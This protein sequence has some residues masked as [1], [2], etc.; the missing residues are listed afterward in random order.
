MVGFRG[1]DA[2]E[3]R[4]TIR[5]IAAGTVGS[6]VLYDVDAETGGLRNIQSG[7][8]V[9]ELI[10][11][12]KAASEIPVLVAADAEGGFY[13]RLKEKYGFG[14]TTPAADMGSRDDLEFTRL[15]AGVI[16]SQLAGVG[17]DLNLAPVVDLLNPANLTVSARRRSFSTDPAKV[18]QHARQF[19]L[20]HREHGV[21]TT[22]KHFPGMGGVLR[23]Y[24]PGLGEL[25]EAWSADE[26]KPYRDFIGEGILDAV[27]ATRVTRPELDQDFPGC[28]SSK[29]IDGLL[30]K[31]LGFS[32][33][34][35]S[36]AMEMMAIWGV[37]GFERSA[38]LAINAGVDLLLYCNESGIVP[39]SDDRGPEAVRVILEAVHRGEI[40]EARINE[41]CGRVL[42]LKARSLS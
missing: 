25:M 21:L 29:I 4:P 22:A 14:P 2:T 1:V 33:V 5:N 15:A 37:H 40:T 36:D 17:I 35:I 9:R 10:S 6:V 3:A 30:R 16:A 26:L 32:G 34:V 13:H 19:I 42:A 24:S 41:A 31:E 11:T 23:P 12:L 18:T 7:D 8:Q 28:L 38:V 27:L 39:Y 20:A